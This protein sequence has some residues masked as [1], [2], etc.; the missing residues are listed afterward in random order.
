MINTSYTNFIKHYT[1]NSFCKHYTKMKLPNEKADRFERSG[2]VKTYNDSGKNKMKY[3]QVDKSINMSTVAN[4]FGMKIK[5]LPTVMDRMMDSVLSYIEGYKETEKFASD[6]ARD[7]EIIL[8]RAEIGERSEEYSRAYA[9]ELKL[10]KE[11]APVCSKFV[12]REAEKS[13]VD[14]IVENSVVNYIND[15]TKRTTDFIA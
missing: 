15:N 4:Q 5:R 10:I 9:P 1:E 14:S 3:N 8:K 12:S 13:Y 2:P 7:G 6:F 11:I